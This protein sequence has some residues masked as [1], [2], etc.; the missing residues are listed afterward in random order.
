M[1]HAMH[2][3]TSLIVCGSGN[4]SVHPSIC[5]GHLGQF[6]PPAIVNNATMNVGV[7]VLGA[8]PPGRRW[9]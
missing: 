3:R 8:A 6:H 4:T 9:P 7:P 1:A 5:E 2:V